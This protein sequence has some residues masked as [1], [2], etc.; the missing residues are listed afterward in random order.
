MEIVGDADCGGDSVLGQA[1]WSSHEAIPPRAGG[2]TNH[3]IV[4]IADQCLLVQRAAERA[5]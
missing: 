5:H 1:L 2:L 3:T 4:I